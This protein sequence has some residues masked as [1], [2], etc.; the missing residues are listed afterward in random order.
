VLK[1]STISVV[2]YA[3]IAVFNEIKLVILL[4]KRI[5]FLLSK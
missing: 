5:S 2:K 1:K 4:W 3:A